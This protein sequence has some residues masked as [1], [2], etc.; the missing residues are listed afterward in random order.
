MTNSNMSIDMLR[1][2]T[3]KAAIKPS[4]GGSFGAATINDP[5]ARTAL[6]T[7]GT[8]KGKTS[9]GSSNS[10]ARVAAAIAENNVPMVATPS[11]PSRT[12]GSDGAAQ[13]KQAGEDERYP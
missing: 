13:P 3:S 6:I 2:I 7:T 11:V 5:V 1:N 10:R 9:T 4:Q 8:I 12:I